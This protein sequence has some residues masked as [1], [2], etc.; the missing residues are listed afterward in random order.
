[1]QLTSS[2]Y[3][4]QCVRK[5]MVLF[6]L[7]ICLFSTFEAQWWSAVSW[8]PDH[9]DK[10]SDQRLEQTPSKMIKSIYREQRNTADSLLLYLI[11]FPYSEKEEALLALSSSVRF[12]STMVRAVCMSNSSRCSYTHTPTQGLHFAVFVVVIKCAQWF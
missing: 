9:I 4:V 2:P 5:R 12:V 11:M 6:L 7:L 8:G 1:M 10:A 3:S